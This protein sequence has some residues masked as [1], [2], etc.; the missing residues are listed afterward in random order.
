MTHDGLR[1]AA[2]SCWAV[3][4]TKVDSEDVEVLIEPTF[5]L[6]NHY[7]SLFDEETR[8]R[9]KELIITL[10]DD[11]REVLEGD[12]VNKLP[13]LSHIPELA[14]VEEKIKG[15]R[16]ELDSRTAFVL[17]A[18]RLSH[19]NSGV[20]LLALME[21]VTFLQE[22]QSY[23]QTSAISPQPDNVI[24]TLFRALLDCAAKFSI[25]QP[26]IGSLCTQCIGLVGCLDSNRI[27]TTR[28]QRSM[29][30]LNN[31]KSMEETVD[32]VL[33]ILEEK[34]VKSFV[35]TPDT[36]LQGYL[37]FAMQELMNNVDIST[38]VDNEEGHG[39]DGLRL[40]QKWLS[41]PEDTREVLRPFSRSRYM[42]APASLPKAEYPIFRPGKPYSNWMRAYALD[43]LQRGQNPH[44]CLLFEPLT[45]VIRV[46]DIS[47]AEFLLPYMVLHVVVGT[48]I[49]PQERDQ[50]TAELLSVLQAQPAEHATY[51]EREDMKLYCEV[52][53]PACPTGQLEPPAFL[54]ANPQ[55]LLF[56]P[57]ST[58]LIT[59]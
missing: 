21:L 7:W 1:S 31:L 44:A 5:F 29:S 55:T 41:L 30:I 24:P 43:L 39:R 3:L 27:E 10:L 46:K 49:E 57:S 54:L 9:A 23:L 42:L 16:R 47:V 15:L 17:F 14:G 45:R 8:T 18:E 35:S 4:L 34:L 40:W 6:I 11:S 37:A 48:E 19:Q 36:K 53:L 51:A 22:D 26:D 56:R 58:C 50:I 38:V 25:S 12:M 32:F 52:S 20:V 59:P 2:F 28:K 33:F 13:R